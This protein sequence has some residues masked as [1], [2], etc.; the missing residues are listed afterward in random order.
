[1]MGELD[2][3]GVFLPS[4]TALALFAYVGLRVLA[5]LLGKIGF[6]QAVWHRSLFNFALYITLFGGFSAAIDWF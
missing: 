6:Y 5:S 4:S 1:M 2:L 3:Y